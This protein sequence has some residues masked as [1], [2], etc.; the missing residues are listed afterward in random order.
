VKVLPQVQ[1]VLRNRD[2]EHLLAECLP[3]LCDMDYGNYSILVVDDGSK[4]S[5]HNFLKKN[6]PDVQL[7][8][9]GKTL[10][11]CQALNAGIEF[12]EAQGAE[13][14]F[15]V[16]TD[17]RNFSKDYLSRVIETFDKDENLG[18]V[19]TLCYD[20]E[21]GKRWSGRVKSKLGV[22]MDTPTEGY[23]LKL[24]VLKK[25]GVFD[26]SLYRYLE[27]LDLII[28]I[29]ES[30]YKTKFIDDVSFDHMGGGM[31]SHQVFIPNYYRMRN[32]IWFLKRYRKD[33]KLNWK[34]NQFKHWSNS[35]VKKVAKAMKNHE[36]GKAA[37]VAGSTCLGIAAGLILPWRPD[38]DF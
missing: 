26:R 28:R 8:E 36:Y 15:V 14:V 34:L 1:V 6:F 2:A 10:E 16:N 23:V 5:P 22:Q 12:A 24:D 25:V 17:T 20:Y 11:Y 13:F 33:Q 18:M 7:L 32:V 19:G 35:H 30:G 38:V 4:S 27:D 29:R 3:T 21:G 9:L 37:A 31:S